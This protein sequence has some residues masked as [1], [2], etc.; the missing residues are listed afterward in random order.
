MNSILLS[1]RPEYVK[2]IL[3]G[4]KKY[5]YRK[6]L[7]NND[8]KYIYIYSTSPEM[9]VV[10][11]VE[12]IDIVRSSPTALWEKTKNAAGI[13]RQNYRQ[14]FKGCKTAF[15]Y[16]LGDVQVYDTPK[17][18]K[19]FGITTAPQSFVYIDDSIIQNNESGAKTI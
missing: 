4:T 6:R 1:I 18:I 8:I 19:D 2:G 17:D 10:G 9:K 7:A 15:A 5:E 13:S 14:Y 3:A 16:Q 11:R 12:I